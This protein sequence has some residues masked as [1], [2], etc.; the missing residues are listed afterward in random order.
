MSIRNSVQSAMPARSRV[1]VASRELDPWRT[2]QSTP[3]SAWRLPKGTTRLEFVTSG[4]SVAI[5]S[6]AV[7]HWS[8]RAGSDAPTA[9]TI[10]QQASNRSD[11]RELSRIP[12]FAGRGIGRNEH[13][14]DLVWSEGLVRLAVRWGTEPEGW[15][16]DRPYAVF[17][18]VNYS[19]LEWDL[20]YQATRFASN[21]LPMVTE[22]KENCAFTRD[23][24]V[25]GRR[26]ARRPS[27]SWSC[28]A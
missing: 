23:S 12:A 9:Q 7:G 6:A 20:N 19:P 24:S 13:R 16:V 22:T 18:G 17:A 15:Y 2:I 4:R 10:A 21:L 27:R 3:F 14:P 1:L 25:A 11:S 8:A 5:S 28:P 26:R